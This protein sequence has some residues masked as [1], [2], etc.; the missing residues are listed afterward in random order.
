[1][2]RRANFRYGRGLDLYCPRPVAARVRDG[3]LLCARVSAAHPLHAT[4]P[5]AVRV[6]AHHPAH[7]R[8][9]SHPAKRKGPLAA[10][11]GNARDREAYPLPAK[12]PILCATPVADII[13]CIKQ[14]HTPY[15]NE[16]AI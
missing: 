7:G 6:S 11:A 12:N 3:A 14:P 5:A 10:D 16:Y 8:G 4:V 2:R 13:I 1:M 9:E 15:K